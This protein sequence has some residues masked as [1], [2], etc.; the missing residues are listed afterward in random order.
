MSDMKGY[1]Y[2]IATLQYFPFVWKRN[3]EYDGIE[4]DLT[5]FLARRF[6]FKYIMTNF[7]K[8]LV[9][10]LYLTSPISYHLIN[11][12]DGAWGSPDE[13]GTWSGLIGHALYGKSNWSI[14]GL[15]VG[16]EVLLN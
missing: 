16:P 2:T 7:F 3:G 4:V 8:F 11:P 9:I 1:N 10:Y 12:P 13:S 15:A 14:S 6:N 5:K